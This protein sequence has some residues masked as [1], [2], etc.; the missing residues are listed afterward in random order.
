MGK[1][2]KV[3][4]VEWIDSTSETGWT[5]DHDLELSTCKTVGY[6]IK[7]TKDKVVLVQSMSDSDSIDNKFAIPRK[8]ITSITELKAQ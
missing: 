1:R 6:L 5:H 8:C 2:L 3:Y 4:L 7:K